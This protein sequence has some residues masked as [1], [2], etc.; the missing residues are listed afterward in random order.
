MFSGLKDSLED[1][2]DSAKKKITEKE[3]SEEEIESVLWNLESSL[4]KNNVALEVIDKIKNNLQEDLKGKEVKRRKAEQFIREELKNTIEE[5]LSQKEIDIRE[6][7][8]KNKPALFLFMGFNGSGKTTTI[9]KVAHTLKK[10]Y[11][12]VLAAGD[13][14]R[15]A[16]IEQ[17]EE[18]ADKLD[19][20]LIKHDYESDSAAVIYDAREFAEKNNKDVIL[21]DTAGRSHTDKNLMDEL[22]KI[23]RVNSPDLKFLVV[24]A[25][26]GN[27]AVEQAKKY[28]EIGFDAII[29]PKVD[30]DERGGS[31]VSLSYTSD[32]P[33]AFIGVGQEYE[34]LEKFEPEKIIKKLFPQ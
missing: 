33:I 14:F 25:L 29:V 32:K 27:D 22:E 5:I 8:E 10:D 20:D 17:L 24:D 12:V 9:G 34:D 4:L 13:T 7:I 30:V 21:A 2:A 19:V 3:L 26:A 18:H 15:A 16:S 6:V 31:L 11:G 1:F 28:Q 23:V